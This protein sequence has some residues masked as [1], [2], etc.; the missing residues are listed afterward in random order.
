[1]SLMANELREAPDAVQRFLD[2]NGAALATLGQ[3]LRAAPPVDG[4]SAGSSTGIRRRRSRR[5]GTAR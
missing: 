3:R 5:A 4:A 2:A 1:M